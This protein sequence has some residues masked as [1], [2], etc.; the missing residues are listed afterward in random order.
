MNGI[1]LFYVD[2][3]EVEILYSQNN[4]YVEKKITTKE[5]NVIDTKLKLGTNGIVSKLFSSEIAGNGIIN[6][7]VIEEKS[8]K[9]NIFEKIC[10]I[11][12]SYPLKELDINM[13][14]GMIV[15]FSD[16]FIL[17]R[18]DS[19][20]MVYEEFDHIDNFSYI[21]NRMRNN[22]CVYTFEMNKSILGSLG[23]DVINNKINSIVLKMQ[24]AKMIKEIHHYSEK[25]YEY[26]PFQFNII[27]EI[28]IKKNGYIVK[29]ILIWR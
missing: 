13:K 2:E 21:M 6:N 20:N 28:N 8:V 15:C 24:S 5:E 22:E 9:I 16:F 3:K 7:S 27:G 26:M 10:I 14:D 1:S 19:G 17:Y 23:Y 25:I 12:E 11:I 18:I 4:E 29:P